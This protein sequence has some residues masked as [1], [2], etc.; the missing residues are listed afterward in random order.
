MKN[1]GSGLCNSLPLTDNRE[2]FPALTRNRKEALIIQLERELGE[3][4]WFSCWEKSN[5]IL[6]YDFKY[7][8]TWKNWPSS[9]RVLHLTIQYGCFMTVSEKLITSNFTSSITD[10]SDKTD[11][12]H[13]IKN[14]LKKR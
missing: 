9:L 8:Q 4:S 3:T 7:G 5:F 10:K 1:L 6:I 11:K 14:K 13:R 2:Y 12:S